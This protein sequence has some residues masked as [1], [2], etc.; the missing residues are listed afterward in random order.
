MPTS[1]YEVD[2]V[3]N[4]QYYPELSPLQ[5]QFV[6]LSKGLIF[7]DLSHGSACEIGS[8]KGI[9]LVM[10]AASQAGSLTWQ[11]TE[12]LSHLAQFS[13][14]LAQAGGVKLT[15]D[16]SNLSEFLSRKDLPGFDYIVVHDVWSFLS[17]AEQNDLVEFIRLKLNLGGV[18]NISYTTS[19]GAVAL[20]P[21]RNLAKEYNLYFIAPDAPLNERKQELS[22]FLVEFLE[23]EPEYRKINPKCVEVVQNLMEQE[24][25]VM[26]RNLLHPHWNMTHFGNVL[27]RLDH[28]K[29][30]F[31]SSAVLSETINSFN[32]TPEQLEFLGTVKSLALYEDTRDL[33]VNRGERSDLFVR[34]SFKYSSSQQLSMMCLTKFVLVAVPSEINYEIN[35]RLGVQKLDDEIYHAVVELLSDYKVYSIQEIANALKTKLQ[36]SVEQLFFAISVLNAVGIISPALARSEIKEEAK[37]QC[38]SLNRAIVSNDSFGEVPCLASPVIQAGVPVTAINMT[39]LK[40]YLANNNI[41]KEELTQYLLD[42]FVS[43]GSTITRDDQVISEPEELRKVLAQEMIEPFFNEQLKL[44]KGLMLI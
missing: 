9:N 2:T 42:I 33:I 44:F 7:P 21:I 11:G 16:N 17:P 24:P 27:K 28:A 26:V 22:N 12:A 19:P 5:A 41:S 39:L 36:I 43:T 25:G 34:G 30:S 37:Q 15:I 32:L 8:G 40:A 4:H 10:N 13:Q 18:L 6:F 20:S 1:G 38:A 3:Y 29:L 23:S 35:T 14:E 31:A